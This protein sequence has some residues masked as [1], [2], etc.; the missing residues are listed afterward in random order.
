M[1]LAFEWDEGKANRNKNIRLISGREATP[2]ERRVYE[3]G[4]F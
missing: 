2:N 4:N 3:Q 1:E